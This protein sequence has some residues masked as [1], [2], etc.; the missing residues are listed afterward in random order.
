MKE[1]I[2]DE[3]MEVDSATED[4]DED[5]DDDRMVAATSK[6]TMSNGDVK[7]AHLTPPAPTFPSNSNSQSQSQSQPFSQSQS[8]LNAPTDSQLNALS[9]DDA[10]PTTSSARIGKAH[11]A[12]SFHSALSKAADGHDKIALGELVREVGEV[13][14]EIVSGP[15]ARRRYE[16]M[17]SCLEDVRAV[18]VKVSLAPALS[19]SP[20]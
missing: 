16:E 20:P 8:Q 17:R 3:K 13:I 10:L 14:Q 4:E 2:K 15:L 11:P 7:A 6:P 9:F 1:G 12:A 19:V 5:E 18:C